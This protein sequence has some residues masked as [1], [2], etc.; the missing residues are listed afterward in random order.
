MQKQ[1]Q[2]GAHAALMDLSIPLKA[3][4]S[5]VLAACEGT[6]ALLW[7]LA[8]VC[9]LEEMWL[10]LAVQTWCRHTACGVPLS[11]RTTVER[12]MMRGTLDV[13]WCFNVGVHDACVES[14]YWSRMGT[15]Q[16]DW[17]PAAE[18]MHFPIR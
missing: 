12:S 11:G 15:R 18:Y 5:A 2:V 1:N 17:C 7:V 10:P 3:F 16:D 4:F 13:P 6:C 9:A 8:V 14:L